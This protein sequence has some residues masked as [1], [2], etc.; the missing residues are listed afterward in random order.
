MIISFQVEDKLQSTPKH[1][2]VQLSQNL[3]SQENI[4]PYCVERQNQFS[5]DYCLISIG[6]VNNFLKLKSRV[7]KVP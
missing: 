3:K 2:P 1:M 4:C 7:L 5:K 6:S